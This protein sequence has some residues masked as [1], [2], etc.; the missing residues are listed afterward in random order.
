MSSRAL[1]MAQL[2]GDAVGRIG[3]SRSIAAFLWNPGVIK[4]G[5]ASDM[6]RRNGH[7]RSVRCLFCGARCFSGGAGW[8]KG[9]ARC[10]N[11]GARRF[12]YEPFGFFLYVGCVAGHRFWIS[13]CARPALPS[14]RRNLD[15]IG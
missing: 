15:H 11:C 9:G 5:G 13:R 6:T 8:Y 10:F 4:V 7:F 1:I 3:N 2:G 14:E 12:G